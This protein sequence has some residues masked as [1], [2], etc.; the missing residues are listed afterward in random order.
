MKLLFDENISH[1]IL[2][3]MQEFFPDSGHVKDFKLLSIED[4]FIFDFAKSK[5]FEAIVTFDEDYRNI[6]LQKGFPP[7]TIWMRTGNIS[8]QN[9]LQVLLSKK[10]EIR[11]FVSESEF[12][13]YS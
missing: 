7:K 11:S 2:P 6:V 1:K 3:R 13:D 12:N 9:L 8:S 5:S 10:E 4:E